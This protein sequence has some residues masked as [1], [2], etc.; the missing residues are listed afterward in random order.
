[1]WA[2][3]VAPHSDPGVRREKAIAILSAFAEV[4]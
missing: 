1:M 4:L 2:Q 3:W